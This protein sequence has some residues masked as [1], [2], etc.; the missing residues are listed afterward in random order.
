MTSISACAV[1]SESSRVRFPARATIS[2]ALT[3]TAPIGTSPREAAASASASAAPMKS[4][5]PE[6]KTLFP[7]KPKTILLSTRAKRQRPQW[8]TTERNFPASMGASQWASKGASQADRAAPATASPHSR[9]SRARRA[10]SLMSS[11]GRKPRRRPES[12]RSATS[13]ATTGQ[14][15]RVR[16]GLR[17]RQSRSARVHHA[18]TGLS[19]N[20]MAAKDASLS[21]SAPTATASHMCAGKMLPATAPSGISSAKS[22]TM[23]RVRSASSR[24]VRKTAARDFSAASVLRVMVLGAGKVLAPSEPKATRASMGASGVPTA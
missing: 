4:A 9:A 3:R 13:G 23:R 6:F 24:R 14:A 15:A 2:P 1:G 22:A 5:R 7:R 11:A 12:G 10:R 19:P 8:T 21:S 16:S 17:A 18:A 20:A